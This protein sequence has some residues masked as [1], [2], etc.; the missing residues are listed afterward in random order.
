MDSF[1]FFFYGLRAVESWISSTLYIE[2]NMN[3][4]IVMPIRYFLSLRQGKGIITDFWLSI[5]I[6]VYVLYE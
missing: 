3:P 1:W 2:T 4:G 5:E 6:Y